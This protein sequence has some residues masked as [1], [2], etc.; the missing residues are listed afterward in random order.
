MVALGCGTVEVGSLVHPERGMMEISL[1]VAS[2]SHPLAGWM[3]WLRAQ[4]GREKVCV[5]LG[6]L[7]WLQHL[8]NFLPRV[9]ENTVGLLSLLITVIATLRVLLFP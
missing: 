8:P 1:K 2:R 4:Q 7:C 6:S 3:K 5:F 9:L